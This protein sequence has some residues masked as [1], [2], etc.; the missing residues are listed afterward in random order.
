MTT[1]SHTALLIIDS[2][3]GFSHPTAW[4][5]ERSNPNYES[6]IT[7]L[8][9]HFRSLPE[10]RPLIIHVYHIS[11][12]RYPSSPFHASSPGV[13]FYDFSKPEG[14][15]PVISKSVNSAFIGTNLEVLL[16]EHEIRTLYIAGLSTDHC[17]STTARMAGNLHVADWQ[18]GEGKE[19]QG[20]V[21]VID[22]ATAAWSK[23][24]GA[25][26]AETVHAVHIESLREFARI[27]RTELVVKETSQ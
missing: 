17:V 27:A 14:S 6:N 16:K 11:S 1:K 9:S 24:G 3:Q 15:E 10:P 18:D 25:W 23:H 4:G 19:V 12:D 7:K 21:V 20:D 5:P 26:D 13:Q 22:D 2:Q 8:L